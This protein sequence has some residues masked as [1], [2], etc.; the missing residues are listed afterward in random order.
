MVNRLHDLAGQL[1]A[2][3]VQGLF[4]KMRRLARDV[5]RKTGKE[6][7]VELEGAETEVDKSI[8]D[9][10]SDPMVHLIRNAV[11]HGLETPK[12][13]AEMGKPSCGRVT[14]SAA[15]RAGNL[16]IEVAD[17]GKGLD[18]EKILTKALEKGLIAPDKAIPT[19]A[20]NKLIFH[21]GFSTQA[22]VS[23][24]SGRGV[25]MD[26]VAKTV[27]RFCGR[28]DV[29][30][31]QGQG[32]RVSLHFPLTLA[33]L[34]GLL[35]KVKNQRYVVPI[36]NV[37]RSVR[38]SK[39]E[40]SSVMNQGE[41]LRSGSEFFPVAKIHERFGLTDGMPNPEEAFLVLVEDR[42]RRGALLVNDILGQQRV[43]VR[44]L[45]EGIGKVSGIGGAA[46]MPDGKVGL[47]FDVSEILSMHT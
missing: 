45:G 38:P 4:E 3:P 34:D 26:V 14:I 2:I 32:T 12:D 33:V 8:V 28:I 9:A 39:G 47:I 21:A 23:D 22:Q 30:T 40:L 6:V 31:T 35:V 16:V 24:I 46:V 15:Q 27:E 10:L 43:V 20:V 42:S 18:R 19:E 13:R 44:G 29:D 37:V 17:D 36:R 11:D 1:R 5:G 7:H 25:G 41:V